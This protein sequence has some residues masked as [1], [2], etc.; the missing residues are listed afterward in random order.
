LSVQAPPSPGTT[1]LVALAKDLV[2]PRAGALEWVTSVLAGPLTLSAVV[3][4]ALTQ[5]RY[6]RARTEDALRGAS[7]FIVPATAALQAM[8]LWEAGAPQAAWVTLGTCLG[9]WLVRSVGR[10][11]GDDGLS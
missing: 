9:A 11:R 2:L 7:A 8:A 6:R 10:V 1:T 4:L 5:L 3:A